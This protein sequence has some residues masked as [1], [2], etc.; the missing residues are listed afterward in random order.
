MTRVRRAHAARA[1]VRRQGRHGDTD[2]GGGQA[3]GLLDAPLQQMRPQVHPRW[4][5]F[6][7]N[8]R[9]AFFNKS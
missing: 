6:R 2:T 9:D 1:L 5:R 8:Q 4:G 3:G 7:Q